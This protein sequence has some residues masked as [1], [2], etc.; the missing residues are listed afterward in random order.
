[1]LGQLFNLI[2]REAFLL[3]LFHLK[4]CE[5]HALFMNTHKTIKRC[6]K[7]FFFTLYRNQ[8]DFPFFFTLKCINLNVTLSGL[9]RYLR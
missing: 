9:I 1:M 5:F 2:N 6:S 8:G 3:K 4:L 7:L